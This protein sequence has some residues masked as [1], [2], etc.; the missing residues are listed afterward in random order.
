MGDE[1]LYQKASPT[2]GCFRGWRKLFGVC[3]EAAID[4]LEKVAVLFS[5]SIECCVNIRGGHQWIK[6][7]RTKFSSKET[8]RATFND[9]LPLLVSMNVKRHIDKYSTRPCFLCH[10]T[11]ITPSLVS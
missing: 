7:A 1:V 8:T 6:A 4:I 11:V 3:F 10:Q 5:V 9:E 2:F